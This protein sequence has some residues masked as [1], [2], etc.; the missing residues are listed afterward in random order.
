MKLKF[1]ICILLYLCSLTIIAQNNDYSKWNLKGKVK[2][3]RETI[4]TVKTDINTKDTVE[5]YYI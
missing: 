4:Y 3:I 1:K 5:Y 2:S